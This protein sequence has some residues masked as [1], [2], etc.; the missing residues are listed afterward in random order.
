MLWS[1]NKKYNVGIFEVRFDG[2]LLSA[3]TFKRD[4]CKTAKT[5][6]RKQIIYN[7]INLKKENKFGQRNI[8]LYSRTYSLHGHVSFVSYKLYTY[9][10]PGPA[11]ARKQRNSMESVE[12]AV[13]ICLRTTYN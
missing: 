1:W 5:K 7:E 12:Y 3:R 9:L 8:V 4:G 6:L 2:A 10:L 11:N 13:S